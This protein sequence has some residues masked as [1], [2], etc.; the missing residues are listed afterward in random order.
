MMR[1]VQSSQGPESPLTILPAAEM[2][3]VMADIEDILSGMDLEEMSSLLQGA[4]QDLEVPQPIPSPP[5]TPAAVL[6]AAEMEQMITTID[7]ILSGM[8]W[9]EI[10]SLLQDAIQELL[11][12]QPI[13]SGASSQVQFLPNEWPVIGGP[14][15]AAPALSHPAAAPPHT[16]NNV[17]VVRLPGVFNYHLQCVA[18]MNGEPVYTLPAAVFPL[19]FSLPAAPQPSTSNSN[20]RKAESEQED[21]RP[22]VKRPPN[23]F[24][25]YMKEH[26]PHVEEDIKKKGNGAVN[27]VLGQRWRSLSEEQQAIYFQQADRE[28]ELHALRYPGWSVRQN[29]GKKRKKERGKATKASKRP[30]VSPEASTSGTAVDGGLDFTENSGG[31]RPP[32]QSQS[33][34]DHTRRQM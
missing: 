2:E 13:P 29:Y 22:Y 1:H 6:P 7:S 12:N 28:R 20:K 16:Y 18:M 25:L 14:L 23:A 15:P 10:S 21:D 33:I 3:H 27:R 9:E 26:R 17:P 24:M 31:A 5:E 11:D 4:I 8:E 19:P 30:G 34:T 32:S